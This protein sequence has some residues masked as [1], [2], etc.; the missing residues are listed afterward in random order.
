MPKGKEHTDPSM[1]CPRASQEAVI[2]LKAYWLLKMC[3]ALWQALYMDYPLSCS[4]QPNKVCVLSLFPFYKWEMDAQRGSITCHSVHSWNQQA[5]LR[6]EPGIPIPGLMLSSSGKLGVPS[7]ES[8]Q[9]AL[10]G[11]SPLLHS[12]KHLRCLCFQFTNWMF[13]ISFS[14]WPLCVLKNQK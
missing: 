1:S 10:P 4:N 5:G 8:L 7:Q 3:P 14:W 9:L 6:R 11:V 2:M 13:W 12:P